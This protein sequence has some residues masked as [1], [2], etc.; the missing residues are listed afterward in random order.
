MAGLIAGKTGALRAALRRAV[1][2]RP[3]LASFHVPLVGGFVTLLALPYIVARRHSLE[4][5]VQ[6]GI[7]AQLVIPGIFSFGSLARYFVW[8][9]EFEFVN[10]VLAYA[11]AAYLLLGYALMAYNAYR[12]GR[13]KEPAY[14]W[15]TRAIE[16]C[17]PLIFS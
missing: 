16:F 3:F 14:R 12:V 6:S 7:A 1:H 8:L 4:A 10:Q 13:G 9:L 5:A 15:F 2:S 11:L 17:R